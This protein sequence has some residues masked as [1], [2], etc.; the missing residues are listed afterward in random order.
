[1]AALLHTFHFGATKKPI[2][3]DQ[4]IFSFESLGII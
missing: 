1:M 3:S 4:L 2:I